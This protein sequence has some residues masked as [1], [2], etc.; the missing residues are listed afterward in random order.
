LVLGTLVLLSPLTHYASHLGLKT[1]LPWR[2]YVKLT[3]T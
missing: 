1:Y 3:F 2:F